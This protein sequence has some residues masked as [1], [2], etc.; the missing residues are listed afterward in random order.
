MILITPEPELGEDRI[1]R[2]DRSIAVPPGVGT[3]EDR[4]GTDPFGASEGGCGVKLPNSSFA[5]VDETI[6]VTVEHEPRVVA[7]RSGPCQPL[8]NAIA[9]E[10]EHNAA[11]RVR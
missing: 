8:P 10:I 11:L 6:V 2:T 7:S 4:K 5:A 3:I 9:V 1:G